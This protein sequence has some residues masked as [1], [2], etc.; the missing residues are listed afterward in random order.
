MPTRTPLTCWRS[1]NRSASPSL[2]PARNVIGLYRPLLQPMGLT[3]PQYLVMLA[4]WEKSPSSLT[5]LAGRLSLE[6]ATLSPLVKRLE[7]VGYVTR[8]RDAKDE[9]ALAVT[10][11]EEGRGPARVRPGRAGWHRRTPRH[12]SN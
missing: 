2:S 1:I 10:L 9:R 5:E 8:A 11:T 6:P 12:A 4:L 3:H 7:A